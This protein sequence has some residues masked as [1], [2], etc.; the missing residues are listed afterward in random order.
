ML[1]QIDNYVYDFELVDDKLHIKITHA[2]EFYEW[3]SVIDNSLIHTE[4]DKNFAV[5]MSVNDLYTILV[6][7]EN[8][9]LDKRNIEIKFNNVTPEEQFSIS[10]IHKIFNKTCKNVILIKPVNFTEFEL[11]TKKL[12]YINNCLKALPTTEKF[13][14]IKK[15]IFGAYDDI[16]NIENDNKKKNILMITTF[17]T[18]NRKLHFYTFY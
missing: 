6:D 18:I 16:E 7:Y 8:K 2:T 10:I 3:F 1:F 11:V 15:D 14:E 4:C 12:N 17:G 13:D 9:V 5:Y